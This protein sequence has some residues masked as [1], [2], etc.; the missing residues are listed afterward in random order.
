MQ[1][2]RPARCR[3]AA[4]GGAEHL[5][6]ALGHADLSPS[7][8]AQ[9]RRARSAAGLDQVAHDLL[10]EER[11]AVGLARGRRCDER[12]RRLAARRATA[13]SVADVALVEPARARR[14]RRGR[15]RRRSASSSA[16]GCAGADLA[17]AVRADDQQRRSSCGAR[18]T[19]RSS[20]SVGRS[21]QCRS[22][23]TSSTG[24]R[25]RRL[26][27]QRGDGLEQQVAARLRVVRARGPEP[28]PP[29]R[30]LGDRAARAPPPP[31]PSGL[32]SDSAGCAT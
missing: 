1:R 2:G 17:V 4:R 28:A 30:Q 24:A 3:A 12:R 5:P 18:S 20:C 16:S 7:G 29:A 32:G 15:S 14:A 25:A 13:I 8:R 10:D 21:A 19:C 23:S 31:G 9:R 11:V 27:Q 26:G 6:D 22:S